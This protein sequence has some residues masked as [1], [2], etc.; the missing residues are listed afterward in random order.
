MLCR[1]GE[2]YLEAEVEDKMFG[3]VLKYRS[4]SMGEGDGG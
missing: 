4:F 1:T 2:F 3:F